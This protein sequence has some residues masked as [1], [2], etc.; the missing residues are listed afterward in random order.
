[1]P[2][3]LT[4]S[5]LGFLRGF[6]QIMLQGSA[7]TGVL[8]ILGIGVGSLTMLMGALVGALSGLVS[9]RLLRFD[10]RLIGQGLYG[11]N[12][13]LVGLAVLF[14]HAPSV[15]SFALVMAG[16]MLSTVIMHVMLT[17]VVSVPA[18]TAPFVIS[19]WLMLFVASHLHLPYAALASI[20]V[21]AGHL[22][23]VLRGVGQ[24]MFQNG[25]VAGLLFLAGLA[26]H[27]PSAAA[28]ATLGSWLGLL[29][30]QGIGFPQEHTTL[31]IYGFNASLVAIAL[32][33]RFKANIFPALFGV[34]LSVWITREFQMAAVPGLTAPFVL[35]TW[36]VIIG[37]RYAPWPR[38]KGGNGRESP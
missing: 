9:A 29:L 32:V 30:A 23:S 13:A 4:H 19:T 38:S 12:A 26:L 18:L 17:K 8:F 14:F 28:W 33:P 36:V 35:A 34:L 24:V 27:A 22:R 2:D 7:L 31:G 10:A 5:L 37:A 25:W 3:T 20:D 11:F 16:G 6:G 1:M 21:E 15:I